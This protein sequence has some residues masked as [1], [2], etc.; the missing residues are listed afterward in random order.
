[1]SH[2]L[3][4]LCG[5]FCHFCLPAVAGDLPPTFNTDSLGDLAPSLNLQFCESVESEFC[6]HPPAFHQNFLPT[7]ALVTH[8]HKLL[9]ESTSPQF[10]CS[11]RTQ[12]NVEGHRF[13]KFV[14][15]KIEGGPTRRCIKG[16][17]MYM[18]LARL[19]LPFSCTSLFVMIFAEKKRH[20]RNP[21]CF[22]DRPVWPSITS[23]LSA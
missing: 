7:L 3:T 1:M 12:R 10:S 21:K 11:K 20:D 2:E 23:F 5:L 14:P 19:S 9:N 13:K 4:L 17:S 8:N 22:C 6:M 18:Y 16:L 15:T